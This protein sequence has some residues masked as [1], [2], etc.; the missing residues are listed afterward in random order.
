MINLKPIGTAYNDRLEIEDDN[1]GQVMTRIELDNEIPADSLWGIEEFSHAEI[2]YYFHKVN[3]DKIVTGARHPRNNV[4]L[5]KVGIFAQRGKNRPNQ[6]GVTI[7]TVV[8]REGNQLIVRGLD[9][10][11][12][13]P[14]LDIKP[15]MH[16]F[17]PR[18][19]FRQPN[20]SQEIMRK[21][22]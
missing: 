16:E 13:T 22:W 11:N 5:P 1:W 6:L 20:W 17:L 3:K 2:V 12:D 4:S 7:V 9:C 8:K 21:Y 18:E 19:S 15:V 10:I 14:I